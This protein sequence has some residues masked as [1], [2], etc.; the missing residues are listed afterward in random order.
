MRIGWPVPVLIT[1]PSL[2]LKTGLSSSPHKEG[3]QKREKGKADAGSP[4]LRPWEGPLPPGEGE[5]QPVGSL[6][7]LPRP[8]AFRQSRGFIDRRLRLKLPGL[9]LDGLIALSRGRQWTEKVE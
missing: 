1:C 4:G 6:L 9:L 7:F 5:A 8:Q 2:S 3:Q